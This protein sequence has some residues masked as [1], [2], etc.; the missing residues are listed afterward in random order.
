MFCKDTCVCV[1]VCVYSRNGFSD[2]V[3]FYYRSFRS[4]KYIFWLK[5]TVYQ[6]IFQPFSLIFIFWFYLTTLF[7]LYS[8][9]LSI[10]FF[11]SSNNLFNLIYLTIIYLTNLF[12]LF[13]STSGH[14][15]LHSHTHNFVTSTYY[16][17]YSNPVL[18]F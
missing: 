17:I 3:H 15:S 16:V 7:Y 11:N 4:K 8:N 18:L 6:N 13:F 2:F 12:N 9:I 5:V 1:C 10:C 14:I